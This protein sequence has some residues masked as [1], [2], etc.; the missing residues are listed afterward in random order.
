M[1]EQKAIEVEIFDKF[2][3]LTPLETIERTWYPRPGSHRDTYLENPM[4]KIGLTFPD[5]SWEL[6]SAELMFMKWQKSDITKIRMLELDFDKLK[7]DELK[8]MSRKKAH[9]EIKQ[10]EAK[11]RKQA[12]AHGKRKK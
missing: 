3:A 8:R 7:L 12:P 5:E 9:E 11:S 1:L 6:E 2:A 10:E 4:T